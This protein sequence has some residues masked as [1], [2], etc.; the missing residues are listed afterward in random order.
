[1]KL[2]IKK[3]L[4]RTGYA[5]SSNRVVPGDRVRAPGKREVIFVLSTVWL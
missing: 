5:F 3:T 4:N 2:L 1:M